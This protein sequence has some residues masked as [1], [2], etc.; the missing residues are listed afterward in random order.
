MPWAIFRPWALAGAVPTSSGDV[1]NTAPAAAR[2]KAIFIMCELLLEALL[3]STG[4][5]L[6]RFRFRAFAKFDRLTRN[7]DLLRSL[8][9]SQGDHPCEAEHDPDGLR[10][11]RRRAE[12]PYK[13]EPRSGR[14]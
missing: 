3:Q 4:T 14:G 8:V 10:A 2:A 1:M 9:A 12:R 5:N 11:A 7:A 6:E 13:E